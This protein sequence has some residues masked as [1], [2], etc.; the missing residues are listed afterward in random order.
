MLFLKHGISWLVAVSGLTS[1]AVLKK[2]T[3]QSSP[4]TRVIAGVTVIDTPIVR[5]AEALAL[6]HSD[7]PIYKHIMR[8]W[9]FGVLMIQANETL[10]QTVDLEVHAI[11]AIL[12]D[13]GW[14]RSE[15]ASFVSRDKRFEVDGA[16]AARNFLRGHE[17]GSTWE[18]RRV[19][20]VWDSIAL[21]TERSIALYK[22]IDVQ[23]VSL[24][25][26]MDFFGPSLGVP[27]AAYDAVVTQFPKDDFRNA[28]NDTII[29]LCATKP[30]TTI[31]EFQHFISSRA[32]LTRSRHVDA[33]LGRKSC[34]GIQHNRPLE[35]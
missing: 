32:Q 33:A 7:F 31:G 34:R 13:L 1:A 29:W 14:E 24:G 17:D 19:Q 27:E 6:R 12:H 10:Q 26:Q 9:L 3:E 18:E 8:S 2:T 5:A 30:E 28:V 23:V 15:N 16:I 4:E 22:E 35:I 11:S 21:H 20:L 25:I